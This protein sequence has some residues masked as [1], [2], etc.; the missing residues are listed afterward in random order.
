MT[1]LIGYGILSGALFSSTFVLNEYMSISGGHWLWSASLRYFFMV[2]IILSIYA[3]QSKAALIV[4]LTK[5]FIRNSTFWCI[6]G[7]LG[8]GAFYSLLCFSAD[9]APG[10]IVAATWQLTIVSSLFVLALFGNSLKKNTW[11]L[12]SVIF[13]GVVIINISQQYG[14]SIESNLWKA[15]IPI[16]LATFCYPFGNQLVWE[17]RNG[18]IKFFSM[19][20][21]E[22][23]DGVFNK[24][25]LLSLG[26]L[27]LWILL[28]FIVRPPPPSA[29]QIYSTITVA[30][31]SGILATGLF[32]YARYQASS[33]E[34]LAAVD[35][36]QSSEVIFALIAS[37]LIFNSPIE[38]LWLALLGILCV[39]GGLITFSRT[40]P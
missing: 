37:L 30:L 39:V 36:T 23:L 27:P 17:A 9:H 26:S 5:E 4:D 25:Y 19:E 10:W 24:I 15:M 8:F 32:F 14:T 29:S 6:A 12:A 13:C 38:H 35:S 21:K 2:A 20:K 34:E 28:F 16:V 22:L 18:K 33:S 1:R 11:V 3:V 31:C 40:K 7:S